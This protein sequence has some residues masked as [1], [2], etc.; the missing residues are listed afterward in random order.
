[1][2]ATIERRVAALEA[3]EAAGDGGDGCPRCR[4]V[5]IILGSAETGE[6][7]RARWNGESLTAE[8]LEERRTET[9]CP[10]C[11]RDLTDD[12][13]AVITIGSRLGSR[14]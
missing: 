2:P 12:D 1:M 3:S 5:M 14:S 8:E 10:R 6:A 7:I 9:R 11:G 13:S 4:G